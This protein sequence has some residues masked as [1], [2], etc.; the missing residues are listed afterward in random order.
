V[1]ENVTVIRGTGDGKVPRNSQKLC[2]SS[3][4]FSQVDPMTSLTRRAVGEIEAESKKLP[5]ADHNHLKK[6]I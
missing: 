4:L 5:R 6:T 2:G 3:P 1:K